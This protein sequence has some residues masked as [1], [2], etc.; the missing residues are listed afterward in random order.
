[1]EE[2]V[3]RGWCFRKEGEDVVRGLIQGGG[4][5]PL[6]LLGALESELLNMDLR[7][8]G[9]K[10]L[11]HPSSIR[12]LSHLQ[13]PKIL[14]ATSSISPSTLIS[15]SYQF[16]LILLRLVIW[17]F[18]GCRSIEASFK[19]SQHRQRLLRFCLTD[20]HSEVVAIEYAQITSMPEEVVPGVKVRLESKIPIHN[21]ILCLDSKVV[22]VMGG[23]VQSL[24]E[25]WQMSQKYSGFSRSTLRLSQSGEGVG[26]PPFEKLQT[27]AH[28][29]QAPQH[30][31]SRGHY[32]YTPKPISKV[33]VP[34][35]EES[36]GSSDKQAA[37]NSGMKIADKCQQASD[38]NTSKEDTNSTTA[39]FAGRNDGKPSSSESRPKEVIE[40]LPVQNQAAAQKLLQRMNQPA[41]DGRQ[42]RASNFRGKGKQ[43]ESVV[44]TLDEWEKRKGGVGG[45]KPLIRDGLHDISRDEELARQLQNQLDLEDFPVKMGSEAEAEKIRMSMFN[46]GGAEQ[47]SEGNEFR[48]RGRGRGRGTGRGRGRRRFG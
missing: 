3:R 1:M 7:D 20:G 26:P 10:S 43:E 47:R 16:L 13:G 40:A 15:F 17:G 21:G 39:S 36:S 29:H 35:V 5:T 24:Y 9:G 25:E 2:L 11:P 37:R 23:L 4:S 18:V 42:A 38:S 33:T 28:P 30:H 41:H 14:Q 27:G 44:F 6:D 32:S 48:G 8:I 46:F 19:D 34:L 31:S 45:V 12:R 22:T